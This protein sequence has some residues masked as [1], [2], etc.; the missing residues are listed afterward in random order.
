MTAC[1]LQDILRRIDN[2]LLAEYANSRTLFPDLDIVGLK[3]TD[4]A[5]I[6]DAIKKMKKDDKDAIERDLRNVATMADKTRIQMLHDALRH[7]DIAFP[8]FKKKRDTHDKAMWALLH[9]QQLFQKTLQ[10]SFPYTESRHWQ[11]FAYRQG[12]EA[13]I[14]QS[15]RDRLSDA[16][17]T[18]FLDYDGRGEHCTVEHHSF[19]D[20]EYL[21]AYPSEYQEQLPEWLDNGLLDRVAHR[22]AF[23]IVFAF[24]KNGASLDIYVQEN[25]QV[26]RALFVLWAKEILGLD[27]VETKPKHSFNLSPFNTANNSIEI[28]DNS[29]IKSFAVYKLRFAPIH[30]PKA[31]Y[32]IEADTSAD[33]QAVY[34]ELERK[35]LNISHIKTLGL[36]VCL[37]PTQDG[38]ESKRRFETSP[39]SCSLKHID[40]SGIIRQFLKEAG[41]DTTQ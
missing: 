21:F 19:Q 18:F 29:R 10:Y 37:H 5:P 39:S 17:K 6:H 35:H 9:H 15:A 8:E 24:H 33:R 30:N 38:K 14:T 13:N 41:I 36:E 12:H 34:K 2:T 40:E 11:K 20:C 23:M 32:T 26:K 25:M 27:N 4:I 1:S 22:L 3:A 7:D 16:I 28:P 31:I